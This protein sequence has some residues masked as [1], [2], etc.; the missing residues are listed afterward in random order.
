MECLMNSNR[1]SRAW[2]W[3]F[4]I[5]AGLT[6]LSITVLVRYN[7]AQQLT[8]A[9]L[10]QARALWAKKGPTDYDMELTQTGNA[11]ANYQVRVRNKKVVRLVQDG[12][13]LEKRLYSSYDM[14]AL[15]GYIGDFLEED[16]RPGMPRTYARGFFDE[17]DGHLVHYVRRVMGTTQRLELS[18]AMHPL[19]PS[20]RATE[21]TGDERR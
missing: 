18:V 14:P 21:Q 16:S 12:R 8:A 4:A 10:D 7:L 17:G 13:P 15:F 2:I 1:P 20:G 6:V 3:Y 11:P 19:P 5:L 9:Q